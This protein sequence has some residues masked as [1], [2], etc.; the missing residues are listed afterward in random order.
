MLYVGIAGGEYTPVQVPEFLNSPST[1]VRQADTI[2]H[3]MTL[4]MLINIQS[5][6]TLGQKRTGRRLGHFSILSKIHRFVYKTVQN[7]QNVK[8][9]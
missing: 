8:Y 1:H 3:L 2:L 4:G 7:Q 9:L 5:G 6:R